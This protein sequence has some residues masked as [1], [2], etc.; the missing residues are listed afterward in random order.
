MSNQYGNMSIV[1]ARDGSLVFCV[2]GSSVDPTYGNFNDNDLIT[3]FFNLQPNGSTGEE[4]LEIGLD[5]WG[6]Q[7]VLDRSLNNDATS[8]YD[9]GDTGGDLNPVNNSNKYRFT[10][11]FRVDEKGSNGTLYFGL[12]SYNASNQSIAVIHNGT[13]S[14]TTN[15]YFAYPGHNISSFT[16]GVWYMLVCYVQPYGSGVVSESESGYYDMS[17]GTKFSASA[18]NISHIGEWGNGVTKTQFR[19]YLYYSTDSEVAISWYEPRIDLVDGNEPSVT[20]MLNHPPNRLTNL[21]GTGY[22]ARARRGLTYDSTYQALNFSRTDY[23][24]LIIPDHNDIDITGDMTIECWVYLN[25]AMN[26]NLCMLINKRY[27]SDYSTPYNMNFEDRNGQNK[28]SWYMGGGSPNY[29]SCGDNDNFNGT[30]NTWNHVVGTVSGTAMKIFVNG[31]AAGTAT[32]S[33][34]RQTNSYALRL[35]GMYS[36]Y[37]T[38][39]YHLD[40]KMGAVRIYSRALSAA[41]ITNNYN[42]HK[43]RYS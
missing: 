25:S 33:G 10:Y 35:G 15:P 13:G 8:N 27:N 9:G 24:Y 38:D 32:F 14:S 36:A 29:S 3:E 40:G 18:G 16:E 17:T 1:S 11:F 22:N 2:D 43:D 28:F 6:R 34:S 4:T 21:A 5:P 39:A 23:S 41:E 20:D 26:G 19:Y 42:T 7:A 37:S 30:Y 12:Y 31:S